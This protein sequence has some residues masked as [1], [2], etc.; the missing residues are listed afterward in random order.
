MCTRQSTQRGPQTR[1]SGAVAPDCLVCTG[2]SGV[3]Q[4]VWPMVSQLQLYQRSTTTD[5]NGRL[6]WPDTTELAFFVECLGHSAKAILHPAKALPSVTLDK[7]YSAN[8]LL[9]KGS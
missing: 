2:L 6:T 5:L 9:A 1:L 3:H 7:E 4:T 8:I